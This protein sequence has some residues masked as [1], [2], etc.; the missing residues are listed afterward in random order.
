MSNLTAL[1]A[2]F[3]AAIRDF[4]QQREP[5]ERLILAGGAAVVAALLLWA[6][7][8]APLYSER[9]RLERVLPALRTDTAL[10]KRDIASV[11]PGAP[12][13]A[14][15]A[16]AD[17]LNFILASSGMGGDGVKP[18]AASPNRVTLRGKA[19]NWG[20][21]LKVLDQARQRGAKVERLS[22]R[23]TEAGAVDVEAELSR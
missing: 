18:E 14:T 13:L 19:V 15:G 22:A 16:L 9:S 6:L 7:V 1:Q 4:W 8:I 17:D 10:F 21:W 5:R 20:S 23:Q 3:P 11:Q 12:A 2:N